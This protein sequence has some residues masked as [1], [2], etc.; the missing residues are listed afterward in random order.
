MAPFDFAHTDSAPP[1]DPICSP[2]SMLSSQYMSDLLELQGPL[3]ATALLVLASISLA[4]THEIHHALLT[5]FLV[6]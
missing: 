4:E 2:E 6:R 1:S 3:L 5:N